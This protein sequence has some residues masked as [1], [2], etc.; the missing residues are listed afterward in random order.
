[1]IK[2]IIITITIILT[3]LSFI[4]AGITVQSIM[5]GE[6]KEITKREDKEDS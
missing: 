1:M 2:I 3:L 5:S 6:Y 4:L